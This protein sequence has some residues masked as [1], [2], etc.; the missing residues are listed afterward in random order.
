MEGS[1]FQTRFCH[2]LLPAQAGAPLAGWAV[3]TLV[4]ALKRPPGSFPQDIPPTSP[5]A[6]PTLPPTTLSSMQ[7]EAEE[8]RTLRGDVVRELERIK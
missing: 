7:M 3:R 6:G 2:S 1:E 4:I 5:L 8:A